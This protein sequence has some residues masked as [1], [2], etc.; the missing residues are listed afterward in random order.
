M[1]LTKA[2]I[3]EHVVAFIGIIVLLAY[4]H[5]TAEAYESDGTMQASPMMFEADW[6]RADAGHSA[7]R[8]H[9]V[10]LAEVSR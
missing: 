10:A 1:K 6:T 9:E 3:L 7:V 4:I 5:G 8:F 2:E